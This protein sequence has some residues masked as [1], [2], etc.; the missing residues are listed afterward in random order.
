MSPTSARV[1]GQESRVRNIHAPKNPLVLIHAPTDSGGEMLRSVAPSL[2]DPANSQTERNSL[3]P[4]Y[5][6]EFE[7]LSALAA[8]QVERRFL[9]RTSAEA[10]A[11]RASSFL[12]TL[13]PP[14]P[15]LLTP[16]PN[17]LISKHPNGSVSPEERCSIEADFLQALASP[18]SGER[19]RG[20]R[21]WSSAPPP[22]SGGSSSRRNRLVAEQRRKKSS[23]SR[24]SEDDASIPSPGGTAEEMDASALFGET[25]PKSAAFC[26]SDLPSPIH[27]SASMEKALRSRIRTS[28]EK[29]SSLSSSLGG[30]EEEGGGEQKA[31]TRAPLRSTTPLHSVSGVVEESEGSVLERSAGIV[32][33]GTTAIDCGSDRTTKKGREW[34]EHP[35]SSASASQKAQNRDTL[36]P[37]WAKLARGPAAHAFAE[38]LAEKARYDAL[39]RPKGFDRR[40]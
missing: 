15:L 36:S 30:A 35:G 4:R 7:R 5:S 38:F 19:R 34:R 14:P 39:A 25:P 9:A 31:A 28:M 11:R 12:S 24:S 32:G 3:T 8:M 6:P 20:A 17:R 29:A 40:A 18:S 16:S 22:P 21:R 26:G 1:K 33:G 2:N 10:G 37:P 23:S 13:I 27:P